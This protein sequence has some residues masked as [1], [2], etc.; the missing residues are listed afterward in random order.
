MTTEPLTVNIP[1][2]PAERRAWIIFQLRMRN[3][4]FR[5]LADREGVSVAA[6]SSAAGGKASSHLQ[7]VL[8]AEVGLPV[9]RLFPELYDDHGKRMGWTREKQRIT[10][11]PA[12]NVEEGKVA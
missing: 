12:C 8:A 2:R 7:A 11:R 3:S 6:V 1:K 9:Q 5:V 10:R 4:S